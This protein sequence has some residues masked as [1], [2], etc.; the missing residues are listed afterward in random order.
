MPR[1]AGVSHSYTRD[2]EKDK[3]QLMCSEKEILEWMASQQR[4]MNPSTAADGH[5]LLQAS[6]P[7]VTVHKLS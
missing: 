7:R 2:K 1:N 3:R 6:R 4:G 5:L